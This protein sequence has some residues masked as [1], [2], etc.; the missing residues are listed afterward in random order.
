VSTTQLRTEILRNKGTPPGFTTKEETGKVKVREHRRNSQFSPCNA[1]ARARTTQ[2]QINPL[3]P[4][5]IKQVAH[6]SEPARTAAETAP[7]HE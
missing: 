3:K 2:T 7:E 1:A 6:K 4:K 5:D